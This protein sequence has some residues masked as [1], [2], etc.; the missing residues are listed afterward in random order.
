[1]NKI[2]SL[3]LVVIVSAGVAYS[4]GH[5]EK[6][7]APSKKT[8]YERVIE[9]GVLRCGYLAEAPFT[10]IDPQTN[11]KSG[12]AVDLAEKIASELNL[13]VEWVAEINFGTFTEDLRNGRFDA[14]CASLFTLPRGGRIDYTQ[15]YA[16]VPVYGYVK[17][18][19][20]DFDGRLDS[21]DWSGV[22]VAGLD[23][24]GATTA[25]RKKIPHA[26]FMILPETAQIADMLLSVVDR[27]AD[28]GFVMPTVFKN[29]DATNP[30]K[31]QRIQ[32]S[33]PFYVFNVSF[34][35]RSDEPAF[36]NMLD[37]EMRN[38]KSEGYIDALFEK[39][40]PDHLL[41]RSQSLYQ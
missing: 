22:T 16:Y 34:G 23:G 25:A 24:E 8:V 19:R 18:G 14:V 17:K 40:D 29:F 28:I 1:M 33:H 2:L 30:D 21:M 41:F 7:D 9:S 27:K 10:I 3:L 26:K 39:Y 13:K 5:H 38:L 12:I 11:K 4:V 20:T 32:T 31:L 6:A 37:F 35:V 15:P 36:K